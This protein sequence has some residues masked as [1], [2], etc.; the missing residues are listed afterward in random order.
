MIL[1][2][3]IELENLRNKNKNKIIGLCHGVFDILHIGHIDHLSEAKKK[4]DILLVSITGDNYVRK[5]PHQP[6]NNHLKRLKFLASLKIIDYVFLNENFT[7]IKLISYLKPN[8]YFKGLDYLHRD[9]TGNLS[10][11][12]KEVK[13]YGGK[14]FITKTK[15]MSSTKILNN[16]IIK[17]TK[18]QKK[19]LAKINSQKPY[20]HIISSLDDLNK[21][22]I[23]IIGDPILDRYVTIK[24][25]GLTSKDPT[26]SSVVDN[27]QVMPGG[28]LA[29]AIIASEFVN[30]V[31]LFTYG[32]GNYLK[33]IFKNKNIEIIN[34][35]H[36]Q[37][38]QTKT[39][40]INSNRYQKVF[41]VT[42]FSRNIFSEK[43]YNKIIRTLNK[44]KI[45]NFII[46]DFGVGLFQNTFLKYI[47]E[48]KFKKFIN[49]Q[50]NSINYGYNLFTKYEN[51]SLEYISL[52]EKE[53]SLGLKKNIINH[54]DVKKAF[55]NSKASLTLGVKGSIY[56]EKNNFYHCPV[57]IDKVVDTTG[58]GDAYFII[59][60]LLNIVKIRPYLVAFL[61]N[62]YAGM[63]SQNLGNINYPK[64]VDF[65]KFFKSVL[66][67]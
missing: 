23:D 29:A 43:D 34:L 39:R 52:D 42:N 15:L 53:W 48:K 64:K 11:E 17:W 40:Y 38:I 6:Y 41:Q 28:V 30:K 24:T 49:V 33:K 27:V 50:T 1:K 9:I 25:V 21:I 54:F 60:S 8:L 51:N 58:C 4:C 2:K 63:H 14:I 12:K 5:G 55:P 45:N 35:D 3:F 18:D 37:N 57:F 16:A 56:I 59:T 46:C 66:S 20:D 36:K 19:T 10:K 44:Y 22:S 62:I 32:S 65:I 13:R 67:F 47:N 7:P 26:I 61:G 31:R